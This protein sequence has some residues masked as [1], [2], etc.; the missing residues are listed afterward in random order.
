MLLFG[1]VIGG[2]LAVIGQG[3]PPADGG[4]DSTAEANDTTDTAERAYLTAVSGERL[5]VV[6]HESPDRLSVFY[7]DEAAN[8]GELVTVAE[9]KGPVPIGMDALAG[10]RVQRWLDTNDEL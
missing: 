8:T 1:F 6:R 9:T 10:Y 2:S 3:D 7:R 5:W 4:T